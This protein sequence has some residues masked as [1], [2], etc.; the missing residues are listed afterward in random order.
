MNEIS[1]KYLSGS[2]ILLTLINLVNYLDRYI[3][4]AVAPLIQEEFSLS[5]FQIGSLMSAFMLGYMITSPI[6]GYFGD[7]YHRPTLMVVG[8]LLWSVATFFSGLATSFVLLFAARVMVG[9]GEASYASIA[10]GYIRDGINNEKLTNKALGIFYTAIP[11]GAA[12]GY[13]WG[14]VAAKHFSWHWAFFIGGIPGIILAVAMLKAKERPREK[15]DANMSLRD[16]SK[17]LVDLVKN[18][19]YVF[20]VLGYTAYTFGLGGFAAWA[21]QFGVKALNAD[22]AEINLLLG[23][24]TILAGTIGTLVGGRYGHLFFNKFKGDTVAAFNRFCMWTSILAAPFAFAVVYVESF[25]L[26]VAAIFMVQTIMFAASAPIN[27]AIL[28]A[29]PS[30]IVTTASAVSI[31]TIHALGD[32]ISPAMVGLLADYM[33]LRSAMLILPMAVVVSAVLWGMQFRKV[34]VHAI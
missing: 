11:I 19:N 9:V 32:L 14:G 20:T 22:L 18:R 34:K 27:T 13:V 26:F 30:R 10:P 21:P 12:L 5:N 33:P 4:T 8:I 7:R 2:L 1:K 3:L 6:F 17:V 16:A 15:S 31:F 23:A 24:V 28:A 25:Y 29:V